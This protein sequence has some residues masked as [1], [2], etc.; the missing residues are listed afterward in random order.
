[1]ARV[2]RLAEQR[3]SDAHNA[4]RPSHNASSNEPLSATRASR[5]RQSSPK[6]AAPATRTFF[7]PWNTSSTGHQRAQNRLSGSTSWRVSRNMKLA[8]QYKSGASGG[9][10]LADTLGAGSNDFGRDGRKENGGW[11]KGAKGLRP[12]GQQSLVDVW[13]ATNAGKKITQENAV[14][15]GETQSEAT[16]SITDDILH[17]EIGTPL[18]FCAHG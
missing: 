6:A 7:D 1:M 3:A 11:E 16:L 18:A 8:E 12:R 4:G 9:R 14:E 17:P 5:P 2:D 13:G 15:A 10:R